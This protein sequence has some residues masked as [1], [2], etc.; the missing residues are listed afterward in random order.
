MSTRV[1]L[2]LRSCNFDVEPLIPS[3]AMT[4]WVPLTAVPTKT[5]VVQREKILVVK[6]ARDTKGWLWYHINKA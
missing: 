1:C 2:S 5:K 3:N 4:I 6:E